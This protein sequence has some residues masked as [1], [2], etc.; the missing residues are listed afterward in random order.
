MK[1]SPFDNLPPLTE[2]QS[3]KI[4]STPISE[5]KLSSDYYKA[6]FHLEKYP[7]GNTERVLLELLESNSLNQAV[8]IAKRKA[9]E[10]L[11]RQ[12][13][14]NAI[15][16]IAKCLY[17][18]DVYLVENA[19]WA[20]SVL[21]C[22][23][24]SIHQ[25]MIQL[26]NEPRQSRRVLVQSLANLEVF[27]AVGPIESLS[28][29]LGIK[30]GLR[31]SCLAAIYKLTGDSRRLKDLK[32]HLSL[33]NQNDRYC[34]VQDVINSNYFPLL[35]FVLKTPVSL[36]FRIKAIEALWPGE[37]E[38]HMGLDLINLLDDS[39]EDN[40]ESLDLLHVYDEE[41]SNEFLLKELFGTDFSR[42]YLALKT[43]KLR[44]TDELWN[45]MV[46]V[47]D[48][49]RKDYGALYFLL[50]FCG[51][52]TDW[53]SGQRQEIINL[54]LEALDKKWPEFMKFKPAA[55]RTLI[56]LDPTLGLE[57]IAKWL[58]PLETPFWI[59][60]YSALRSICL[61]K[62]VDTKNILLPLIR[63]SQTDPHRFVRIKARYIDK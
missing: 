8:L 7:S 2:K 26:L 47:L 42:C 29:Q 22:F 25:K 37:L 30:P 38:K 3:L 52:I 58:D 16:Q 50:N 60:R 23:D 61:M 51:S 39:I 12:Q 24:R 56:K 43:L 33:S 45:S 34:A 32:D 62:D 1:A 48:M 15:P 53:T 4:L 14:K 28:S 40:P 17:S 54:S 19:V 18:E 31:G 44:K 27:D 11:A 5:L 41:P 46:Q 21:K 13:C 35:E 59:S 10:V 6:V 63:T 9:V 55:I 49:M 20:L 36:P 57:M